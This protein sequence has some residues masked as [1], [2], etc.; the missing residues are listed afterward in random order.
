MPKVNILVN[1]IGIFDPK[2]FKSIPD[3][4]WFKFFEVNVMSGVRLS[5]T[6]FDKMLAKNW[7]RIIFSSG[8]GVQIP[9]EMIHYGVTKAARISVARGLA[10]LTASTGVTVTPCC[11]AQL[12][13]KVPASLLKP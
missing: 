8:S 4:E 12:L 6:Y 2:E 11:L 13:L 7:G 1:N 10:E 5:R 9:A 3:E